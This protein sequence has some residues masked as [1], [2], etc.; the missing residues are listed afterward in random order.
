MAVIG[1]EREFFAVFDREHNRKSAFIAIFLCRTLER[2]LDLRTRAGIDGGLTDRL[3]ESRTGHTADAAAA[4]DDDAAVRATD[5]RRNEHAVRDVRVVARILAH[6]A[7]RLAVMQ[8]RL[9]DRQVERHA[10]RRE[11]PD[12][13]RCA[14]RQQQDRRRLRCRRSARTC[15]PAA[16]QR[17][18]TAVNRE[19]TR[20]RA[21]SFFS[22][23]MQFIL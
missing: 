16:P 11:Q 13:R 15:C 18:R 17:F 7:D 6:R 20:H 23:E 8:A 1:L 14:P 21:P 19:R 10:T 5:G 12:F 22:I 2:R 4:V 3:R 9:L